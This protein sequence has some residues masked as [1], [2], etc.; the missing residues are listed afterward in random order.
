MSFPIRLE[1]EHFKKLSEKYTKSKIFF[2][3]ISAVLEKKQHGLVFTNSNITPTSFLIIHK[4]GF[5]QFFEIE[6][7]IEFDRSII[8]Y[9]TRINF[10][11]SLELSKIR[12]YCTDGK[13]TDCFNLLKGNS[14][15]KATRSRMIFNHPHENVDKIGENHSLSVVDAINFERVNRSFDLHLDKRF[16][17]TKSDFLSNSLAVIVADNDTITSICYAAAVSN[18]CAEI[19]IYTSDECRGKGQAKVNLAAFIKICDVAGI[20]P[21]WDC[22]KNNE[23]SYNLAIAM[24]FKLKFEYDF[25]VIDLSKNR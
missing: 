1:L 9:L 15:A 20:K 16:W 17:N 24:G 12:V 5:A 21:Y 14:F 19:D 23:P 11:E 7:S 13:W 25:F 4:F 10:I 18:N 2:P 22:Y 3:L 6:E 8:E